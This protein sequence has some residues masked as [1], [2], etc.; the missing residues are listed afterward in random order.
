MKTI[1]E[2]SDGKANEV[3][4]I[5]K[6]GRIPRQAPAHIKACCFEG[7]AVARALTTATLIPSVA[8]GVSAVTARLA[9]A[10]VPNSWKPKPV[11]AR[12]KMTTAEAPVTMAAPVLDSRSSTIPVFVTS[13]YIAVANDSEFTTF[14]QFGCSRYLQLRGNNSY[15]PEPESIGPVPI[16]LLKRPM[17][18]FATSAWSRSLFMQLGLCQLAIVQRSHQS[19]SVVASCAPNG[20]D[21]YYLG[22]ANG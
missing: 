11:A 17:S 3:A 4:T 2:A 9:T 16:H 19:A 18:S 22:S 12:W 13:I 14:L 7:S 8:T 1:N 21:A 5:R 15:E 20:A 10:Q 6:D